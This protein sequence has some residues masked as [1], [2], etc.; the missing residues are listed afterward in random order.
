[1]KPRLLSF[2]VVALALVFLVNP[3]SSHSQTATLF[4]R[5]VPNGI[6]S[7]SGERFHQRIEVTLSGSPQSQSVFLTVT[8][9]PEVSL[10]TTSP[11]A[12]TSLATASALVNTV[13]GT[14]KFDISLTAVGAALGPDL[15]LAVVTLEFDVT[16]PTNYTGIPSG[17]KVDTVY[18][19]DFSAGANSTDINLAVAKNQDSGV[20]SLS[21]T[22]PDSTN[23]DTTT[24]GGRFYKLTFPAA[25]PDYVHTDLS[26]LGGTVQGRADQTSDVLYSFYLSENPD[27][28]E[29]PLNLTP[30]GFVSQRVPADPTDAVVLAGTRQVPRVIP[31]TFIRED[32]VAQFGGVANKD[33]LSGLISLAG[34]Q[35]ATVYYVYALADPSQGRT[36]Y[37][38]TKYGELSGGVFI[39]RSGALLVQHPPEFVVAGW[40]FDDDATVDDY[41]AT[42]VIQIPSDMIDM[43]D[44]DTD[45]AGTNEKDNRDITVDSGSWFEKGAQFAGVNSGNPLS[46][47]STVDL[48]FLPQ[49][50]DNPQ[51]F[52]MNIFLSTS[53]GLTVAN[54][55]NAAPD[56][57][58]LTGA[59]K[60]SG[61]D[62]LTANSRKFVFNPIT[63]D[64][65]TGLVTDYIP[66]GTYYV[67]F[68]ASDGTSRTLSQVYRDPFIA[69][70]T[71][72]KLTVKHAPALTV[73]S[74][75]LN[76]FNGGF[77][78]LDVVTGIDV[79]QMLA[80][81][82][83]DGKDLN[84]GPAQ[85]SIT[86]S[87]GENG[88]NGDLDVDDDAT[89]DFYYSTMSHFND[90]RGKVANTPANSTGADLLNYVTN[91]AGDLHKIGSTTENPDGKYDNQFTWD[92][93]SYVSPA[94]TVPRTG[95]KYYLY[96]ILKGGTTQRLV[97]LTQDTPGSSTA[98]S[99]AIDFKHPPYIRPVEPARD[100]TVTVDEPVL[101]SWD[102]IDVDNAEDLPGTPDG[103]GRSAQNSRS[104]S[105]N[106]RILL[107]S[108]DFGEVTSWG[109]ITSQIAAGTPGYQP[110]RFWVGNSFN[111]GLGSEIELNEG[112]DTSF[113]IVG[114]RMRTDLFSTTGLGPATATSKPLQTESGVGKSYYVYFAID[115]GRDGVV[116]DAVTAGGAQSTNFGAASPVVRAPGRITF[117]GTVPTNPPSSTRFIIPKK[118]E[119]VTDEILKYPIIP[120]VFP[121][122]TSV[123]V[124]DI[125]MSVDSTLFEAVDT[126]PSIAGIQPFSLGDNSQLSAANVS[127]AAYIHNGQLRLDFIYTGALTYFNAQD[128]LVTANLRAKVLSGD[129]STVTTTISVDDSGNRVTKMLN[130]SGNDLNAFVPNPTSVTINRR[131]RISGKVPLQGRT[132]SADTVTFFLRQIGS[133]ETISDSLFNLNDIDAGLYG[134]QVATTDFDGKFSLRNVPSGRLMLSASAPRYLTGHDSIVV[135]PGL[136]M[137]DLLPTR[138]GDGVQ[139]TALLAGDAAGY[140]DSTGA[141]LPDGQI[142]AEDVNAVNSALFT[143]EGD[144]LYNTYADINRDGI[145]NATD[146]D[147]TSANGT[148]NTGATGDIRPVFPVFKQA[149]AEGS[150]T[151]ALVTLGE[152]PDREIRAGEVFDVT[153]NVSG[154]HAVRT[155]E[156]HL[157]FDPTKL[158]VADLNTSGSLLDNYMTDLS[159]KMVDGELGLVNSI[160]GRTPVGASGEGTLATVRFR[161]I[162]RSSETVV[163]LSD[164]MLIDVDHTSEKPK[165]SG[166]ARI[167]LSK[168]PIVYHDA[169]GAEIRGLILA[170]ADAKV[171]FNDFV[172]LVQAFGTSSGETGYDL[173][174]DLNGDDKV[175][176]AD[177]LLFSQDFGKEAVDA[178]SALRA[179]KPVVLEGVNQDAQVSLGV[180]GNARMGEELTL[181][182]TLSQSES[183]QGW[184]L[185]VKYD[186]EQ[187]EF[188]DAVAPQ[189]NL[190]TSQGGS[191]PVFL[192]HQDGEGQVSVANAVSEGAAGSGEGVLAVLRFRP[193]GEFEQGMFEV[194]DG[195]LF[196]TNQLSNRAYADAALEVRMVPT[197]FALAQNYPNPFNPETTITYDVAEGSP[198]RLEVYNVMGQLV[199]TLVNEQQAAGRYRVVW[200]G[201]D[202][203][204]RQVASGVYFYRLQTEGFSAVK[205]LMLLK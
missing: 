11:T 35:D 76:D 148:D 63:T 39:G 204:S 139:R 22:G 190:L 8:M 30:V 178:P 112:V 142:T 124:V 69:T 143:L 199:H 12:T 205:K 129:T 53:S 115:D 177:F 108:A 31:A 202:A 150:N 106:I 71:A 96:A 29:R 93:W 185:S 118:L 125:F 57:S 81:G 179:T 17:T 2:F 80:G 119:S 138:D 82:D 34:T 56:I 64:P 188:V 51:D 99:L 32:F 6:A 161:A 5:Q 42:G 164:A 43:A 182:A 160:I 153:V 13:G 15:P 61:T 130:S 145:V 122:G 141:N 154:A 184:G 151:E 62:T 163:K 33:S 25:L 195:I 127:Q 66:E 23:G 16:T 168:D 146:K 78:D 50:A 147:Y 67:Y 47:I 86:I 140:Q 94:G 48:L 20:R 49:D 175:N 113:V 203:Q 176:F 134:V 83:V 186:P 149:L 41:D 65:T 36:G 37:D 79:S 73:D 198:V 155:Y 194:Y 189:E 187:Y 170:D 87:W 84:F 116:G 174:A 107:T 109:S 74:W 136:D 18:A 3:Q 68:A 114:N 110:D 59:T 101:V 97:S 24:A 200:S 4:P 166:E 111:G 88:L 193:K 26:G 45:A 181:T 105:P 98:V 171:D 152:M 10:V 135:K 27:L 60:V 72:A 89:I 55:T 85:R 173:M 44:L 120:E 131:S 167:V 137:T 156:V 172:V 90:S 126:N 133:F 95:T 197:A 117:T 165:V 162:S 91:N 201:M 40:D 28:V 123:D 100:I 144:S 132:S 70:P 159:G 1:M 92:L 158:A 14:T 102:A 52:Q 180:V 21:F 46:A 157:E 192:V 169:Q 38:P 9:P 191:T 196:D 54:F 19:I 103:R 104:T 7:I 183:V 75:S 77:G 121:S 58:A 128:V